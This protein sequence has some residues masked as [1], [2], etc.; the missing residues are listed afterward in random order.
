[1]QKIFLVVIAFLLSLNIFAQ[2]FK[3]DYFKFKIN[4][5]SELTKISQLISIDNVKDS[6]V[7]AYAT[8]DEFS[9]FKKLGYEVIFIKSR[10]K[11]YN[12]AT[13]VAE[14]SNWDKYPTYEVYRK[15]MKNFELNY[16][17]I[18]KLDS[19]G[20]TQNNRKLYVL[21]ISDNI[22]NE[23]N[24]P[25]VFYT[26]TMHGDE[27]AGFII[28]L[29]LIDSLLVSYNNDTYITNLI[30]NTEIYINPNANP[31]GTYYGGNHTVA[32]AIRYNGF[33]DLNRDFPDPRIGANTPYQLETQAMMTFAYNHNFVLAANFH[34]GTEVINYPWDTWTGNQYDYHPHPDSEW[35]KYISSQY[36]QTARQVNPSYMTALYNEGITNGG[37]WYIIT[38][39]RQ[40]YMNYWHHCRE[41]TIELSVEKK[42]NTNQFENYWNYNKHSLLNLINESLYGIRGIVKDKNSNPIKACIK[43]LNHDIASDSSMVFTDPDVGNYH[44]LIKAGTYS[45]VALAPGFISDTIENVVVNDGNI[46]I[47]DFTLDNSIVDRNTSYWN[48]YI[49]F[50]I[51]PNPFTEF[52][53][54][55]CNTNQKLYVEIFNLSGRKIF[56]K[57]YNAGKNLENR[58]NIKSSDLDNLPNGLY[59]IQLK[60]GNKTISKVISKNE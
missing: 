12:M 23:E 29:R 21:K 26:S 14:M 22:D 5:K 33:T 1:M 44:R 36:V 49:N 43:I 37:D 17:L 42:L 31:D 25:E 51:Y 35:F 27:T 54:I 24:E 8:P 2:N 3:C 19:I 7:Y 45:I 4:D 53:N 38:G 10:L 6:I 11:P 46:Q 60:S 15:L 32:N 55:E 41:I 18:C 47:V 56:S 30:N 52:I 57:E 16:P 28:M 58:F 13:T 40:D 48:E 59:V 39:G 50:K 34:G 9:S 20:T